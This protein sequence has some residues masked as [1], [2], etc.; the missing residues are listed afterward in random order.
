MWTKVNVEW[1]IVSIERR[2]VNVSIYISVMTMNV[3]VC[4]V[5]MNMNVWIGSIYICVMSMNVYVCIWTWMFAFVLA[6]KHECLCLCLHCEHECL[7]LHV[8][9]GK[10][11]SIYKG[12][13]MIW[14]V[15]EW[16]QRNTNNFIMNDYEH[17]MNMS[18]CEWLWTSKKHK[19]LWT[20]M[21]I[22]EWLCVTTLALG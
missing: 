10:F 11:V 3:Y 16:L 18:D 8:Q 4:I 2:S 22:Y 7:C 14:E 19:W 15:C 13:W 20:T 5:S 21:K 12:A 9:S 17:Q 1:K 6:S